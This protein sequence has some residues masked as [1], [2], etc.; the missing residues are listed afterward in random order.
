M[1]K[2]SKKTKIVLIIA[3]AFLVAAIVSAPILIREVAEWPF[4][5]Y[6]KLTALVDIIEKRQIYWE[7]GDDP[8]L[9]A[10]QAVL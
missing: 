2:L 8:M 1:H 9:I 4:F 5:Q 6:L 3:A 7:E 10:Y